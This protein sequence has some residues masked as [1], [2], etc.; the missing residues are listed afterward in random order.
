M[1]LS[2]LLK[3]GKLCFS[4][5]DT[6]SF[7]MFRLIPGIFGHAKIMLRYFKTSNIISNVIGSCFN[8]QPLVF[9]YRHVYVRSH[10][11]LFD[12]LSFQFFDMSSCPGCC[13]DILSNNSR[14]TCVRC[15]EQQGSQH[16]HHRKTERKECK[17]VQFQQIIGWL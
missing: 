15:K 16:P 6:C 4:D 11:E 17:G 14:L 13:E 8:I 12:C 9:V 3:S 7:V 2:G 5:F 1:A 10:L